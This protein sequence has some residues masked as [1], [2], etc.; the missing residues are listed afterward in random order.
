MDKS[1]LYIPI[2]PDVFLSVFSS[3]LFLS[4]DESAS[5]RGESR[6]QLQEGK[7]YEYEFVDSTDNQLEGWS[8]DG[9]SAMIQSNPHHKSRGRIVTGLYVGTA[10]FQ[11][12]REGS[13]D[14]ILIIIEI[15][16]VKVKYRQDYVKMMSDITSDYAEL[17]MQQ[18]SP[19]SQKF[20][21]N[22]DASA[23][24]LYQKFAFVKSIIEDE[25]FE[26]AIQQIISN[27]IRKWADSTAERHIES[28]KRL[29]KS[30]IRQIVTRKDRV[31]YTGHGIKLDSL[32]RYVT[33]T[34]KVDTIDNPENQ[35]VK[36]VLTSFYGFC[37]NLAS[38]QSAGQE[39]RSEIDVV[40]GILANY[41]SSPFFK[42][43]SNPSH[44]NY[45]S[46]VLQRKEGYREVLQA[47]LKFDLAARL[48]WTGGDD[49]Y[50]AGQKNIA[51]LYEYWVFFKLLKCVGEVFSINPEDKRNLIDDEKEVIDLNLRQ[52]ET[53]M[54]S[55]SFTKR[56]RHLNIKLYYNRTFGYVEHNDLGT[57]GSWTV[58]M[59]PDYTLSIWPGEL[60][61]DQAEKEDVIVH[62][63]FDAKYRIDTIVI[64]D[65]GKRKE[66]VQEELQDE[67]K[68][69]EI[70][71]YKRGD[72]L[73]MHA[74]KDA[75]RR[76]AG[77][78][79]IYP[80]D[81]PRTAQGFHE[82]IPGLGAFCLTP[83]K[84]DEDYQLPTLR[85]FLNDI[86]EHFM[87]RTSQRE[88][89]ALNDHNVHTSPLDPFYEQFPEPYSYSTFADAVWVLVGSFKNKGHLDWILKNK[90]YAIPCTFTKEG[91]IKMDDTHLNLKYLLLY[92]RTDLTV[93]YIMKMTAP[94]P[95]IVPGT[96]LVG[97]GYPVKVKSGQ[98]Y[99]LYNV[100]VDDVE[101]ELRDRQWGIKHLVE[102]KK[103]KPQ[104]VL[105]TNLFRDKAVDN[106]P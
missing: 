43:I 71:V 62:V 51:T 40:C 69:R 34:Q 91:T 8:L 25:Q 54:I 56:N 2:L 50:Y 37:S 16:S 76:T 28:V 53:T 46:P 86:V 22:Y 106:R 13:T 19:V 49:I 39:L 31:P 104:T 105:Y 47:W 70:N 29:S 84:E 79:V 7:E 18:G 67:K 17:V 68:N 20:E 1:Q 52:G 27:P 23:R 97:M 41:L 57:A 36:F 38:K 12:I 9:P 61:E 94:H 45:G 82:I 93:R 72:L 65:K 6:W 21:V 87:N 33:V 75:I 103:G 88:K 85:K 80:G 78:Y 89:I 14:T 99:M 32:P 66:V 24:T 92:A 30:S 60:T 73:K 63:H 100:S 90:K 55:G 11:A 64:D 74:Y 81:K 4:E 96:T 98:L 83:G 77:A 5:A 101:A 26:E 58:N 48:N 44:L 10:K 15:Q 3:G 42:D 102:G 35:F 95:V 59:R